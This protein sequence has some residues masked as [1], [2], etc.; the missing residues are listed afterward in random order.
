MGRGLTLRIVLPFSLLF[1]LLTGASGWYAANRAA[2]VTEQRLLQRMRDVAAELSRLPLGNRPE[3]LSRIKAVV[4]LD[5]AIADVTGQVRQT[6]GQAANEPLSKLLPG[7]AQQ[8]RI[9][10]D[11]RE[12]R[13]I[14]GKVDGPFLTGLLLLVPERRIHR[15]REE[16][17]RGILLAALIAVALAVLLGTILAVSLAR[18]IARLAAQAQRIAEGDLDQRVMPG[19]PRELVAL[20]ESFNRMVE[21]LARSRA[22]LVEAEK[23]A[24]LGRIATAVAHEIRNPLTPMRMTVQLLLEQV[25]E[26]ARADLQVVL[27]EI[28]RIDTV[29]GELLTLGRPGAPVMQDIDL[30]APVGEIVRLVEGRF[31][32]RRIALLREFPEAPLLVRADPDR[33][34]QALM[35]LL[36][37]A[38]EASPS[39]CSVT[40]KLYREAG[41]VR[42]VVEDQAGG[43]TAPEKLFT[44]FFTTKPEGTGIGLVLCQTIAEAHG[45]S[46]VHQAIEG[47]SRF[48]LSLPDDQADP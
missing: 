28:D 40:V 13:Y 1:A 30:R 8:G 11:G 18:P 42:I 44:P 32:H 29:V 46:V 24:L 3:E 48:Q 25:S 37:N 47:G 12:Y 33:I 21:S 26:E 2:A 38:L 23:R 45:G 4:D 17:A 35:N 5:L 19:G 20:G 36:L 41:E 6:L 27:N 10:L 14:R 34:K 22:E 43:V 39:D 31:A 16:A 15:A 7:K 9:R